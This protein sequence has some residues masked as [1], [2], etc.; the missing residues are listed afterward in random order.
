MRRRKIHSILLP[1]ML[2]AIV[3]AA[4]L[5]SCSGSDAPTAFQS[6]A[7]ADL[8]DLRTLLPTLNAGLS[9]LPDAASL[10]SASGRT[11]ILDIERTSTSP[12]IW[13]GMLTAYAGSTGTS[14]MLPSRQVRTGAARWSRAPA[15]G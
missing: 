12:V 3:T 11:T 6:Q 10:G 4:G 1:T 8:Q 5:V 15:P 2:L 14:Y 13:S 9:L 7:A